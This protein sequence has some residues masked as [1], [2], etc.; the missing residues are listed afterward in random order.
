MA[1]YIEMCMLANVLF[2]SQVRVLY[3]WSVFCMELFVVRFLGKI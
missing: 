2:S 3:I 1:N